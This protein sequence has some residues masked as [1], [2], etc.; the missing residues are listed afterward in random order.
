L[1]IY[2]KGNGKCNKGEVMKRDRTDRKPVNRGERTNRLKGEWKTRDGLCL[3]TQRLNY[4]GGLGRFH[5]QSSHF[6]AGYVSTGRDDCGLG[7]REGITF[8]SLL[9][10]LS[11]VTAPDEGTT[12]NLRQK[13]IVF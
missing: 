4:N 6:E 9:G 7:G 3:G 1:K 10:R 12:N 8:H 13:S 5:F 11:A 2:L